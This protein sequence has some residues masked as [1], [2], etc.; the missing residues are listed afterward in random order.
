MMMT[1]MNTDKLKEDKLKTLD[2]LSRQFEKYADDKK[3]KGSP[4]VE[5]PVYVADLNHY[6]IKPD[7]FSEIIFLINK[8]EKSIKI[9]GRSDPDEVN[10]YFFYYQNNKGAEEPSVFDVRVP[11]NFKEVLKKLKQQLDGK[12]EGAAGNTSGSKVRFNAL[13][14]VIIYG[15]VR[16]AFHKG[17]RDDAMRLKLF[18]LLW[19]HRQV[20]K[21]GNVK[22]KG[23]MMQ[24][25]Y[26]AAQ[27][28]ISFDASS[29]ARNNKAKEALKG[30][31][32]NTR[33]VLKDKNI[34]IKIVRKNGVLLVVEE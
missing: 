18:K 24:A 2:L 19:E 8:S 7:I 14:A 31:I 30:L 3:K 21:N 20:K 29:F 10:N 22:T 33:R 16:H 15:D 11:V 9:T 34:P 28:G 13:N 17:D 23:E 1:M 4:D 6:G 12:D 27:T 26:L 25:G 5:I 32:K